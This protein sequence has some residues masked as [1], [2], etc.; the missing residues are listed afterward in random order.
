ML[1]N[2]VVGSFAVR[3]AATFVVGAY[4]CL[5]EHGILGSKHLV[6]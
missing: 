6:G 1:L 5:V 2:S 3:G 4:V